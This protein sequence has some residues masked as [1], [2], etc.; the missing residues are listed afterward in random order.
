[1]ILNFERHI[2]VTTKVDLFKSILAKI[3]QN[4]GTIFSFENS[5]EVAV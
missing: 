1:M 5:S 2:N 3:R 4:P